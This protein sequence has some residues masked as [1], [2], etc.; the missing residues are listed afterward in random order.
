MDLYLALRYI[1]RSTFRKALT[2]II[3]KTSTK[4]AQKNPLCSHEHNDYFALF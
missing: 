1:M 4:V 3:E 2:N